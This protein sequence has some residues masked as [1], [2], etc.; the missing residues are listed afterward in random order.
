[1]KNTRLF[2]ALATIALAL[3]C[4]TVHA[5]TKADDCKGIR[6]TALMYCDMQQICTNI[7]ED[8]LVHYCSTE[9]EAADKCDEIKFALNDELQACWAT[10]GEFDDR[11]EP[12]SDRL[13]A[14]VEKCLPL[15]DKLF[16]C[17]AY[18]KETCEE[19]IPAAG[20]WINY[21]ECWS[22]TNHNIQKI[23]DWFPQCFKGLVN[24]SGNFVEC[25]L[26]REAQAK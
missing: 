4:S 3:Q 16:A 2:V 9:K 14:Q 10:Y 19:R 13:S 20:F 11:C 6:Q 21:E 23:Y 8:C 18:Y 5:A 17:N 12:I 7:Y 22:S 1:M 26:L 25:D 15:N 24:T